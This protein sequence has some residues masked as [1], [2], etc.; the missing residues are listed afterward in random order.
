MKLLEKIAMAIT[1]LFPLWL[2]LFSGLAFLYP[3]SLKMQGPLVTYLLG[4]IMLGM[5]LSMSVADFKLVLSR[6][7]DV[8]TGIVLRYLIMP[9]V[10]FGV[11]KVLGLPPALA[12][13]LILVGCCPSGTASNVMSFLAKA[14]TALSVTV[15][16]FNIILA[17][18]L[19]PTTFMLL[20]G[21]EVHV[22]TQAMFMDV[23][24]IV[25]GPV[26]TGM[27]LRGLF[28]SFVDR[29]MKIVPVVSVIAIILAIAIVVAMS[30]AKLMTVALIAFIAVAMHNGLGLLFGYG[31]SKALGL[32]ERQ[33]R[34]IT[35]EIGIEMSGLAVV[36]AIAHL[37][38]LAAVPGAIFSVWHNLTG[39]I[40]AGYWANKPVKEN[41]GE[42]VANNCDSKVN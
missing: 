37:E 17:P 26:I 42:A 30:A 7:R 20:A 28:G 22:N 13:G 4:T 14:D 24:K 40:I 29:I 18:L 27:V 36:L 5:G 25:L 39:S 8:I 11:A 1:K 19:L 9:I 33:A 38:P 2:I 34:A 21:A 12:A 32:G 23:V 3:D 35:F 16:S 41:R 10:G 6:P 15:S 31:T